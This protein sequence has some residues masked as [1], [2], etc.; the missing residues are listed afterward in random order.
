MTGLAKLD[1]AT[2]LTSRYSRHNEHCKY[3]VQLLVHSIT[4]ATQGTV[5]VYVQS[6]DTTGGVNTNF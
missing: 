2:E 5:V 6:K 3:M 4:I 1:L